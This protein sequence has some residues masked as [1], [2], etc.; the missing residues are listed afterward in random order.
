MRQNEMHPS[1]VRQRQKRI[2]TILLDILQKI[3]IGQSQRADRLL[4]IAYK[5]SA[6]R[7]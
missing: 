3:Q 7:G 4:K 2:F 6:L 5:R 1:S